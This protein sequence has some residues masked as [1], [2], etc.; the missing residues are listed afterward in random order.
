MLLFAGEKERFRPDISDFFRKQAERGGKVTYREGKG[1]Q[2][3]YPLYPTPEGREARR[4]IY[5][6]LQN[7][8]YGEKK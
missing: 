1:Q 5:E 7:T 4:E 2:H 8:I 6:K 3:C